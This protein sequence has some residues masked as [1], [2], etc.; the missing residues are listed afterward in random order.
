[1]KKQL[2]ILVVALSATASAAFSQ[3]LP[4][5]KPVPLTCILTDPLQPVAGRPYDYSAIINPTGGTAYWYATKSTTFTSAGVRVATEIPADGVAIATGA[6]NY[7]TSAV[8]PTSP[9]VT[10]VTWTS[11]GLAGIDATTNPL[12]MIVEYAG[13]TCSNNM[14]VMQI[15]PKNAF[16]VDITNMTHGVSPASLAYGA[17]ESQ[18]YDNVTSAVFNAG[19]IDIDY[20]TNVLYF[21]VIAANFS[22]SYLPTLK[23][24]GLQGTQTANIDWGYAIGTYSNNLVTNQTG[25]LITTA[26]FTVTTT[27]PTDQGISIY[28]RVTVKNHGWE[29]L[30]NDNITLAVEAVDAAGN[31]DV[32]PDCTTFIPFG[33]LAM[34]TLNARP[35]I[36]PGTPMIPQNP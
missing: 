21:E 27:V 18:C 33:D 14:K 5:T 29:G 23:L 25:S 19:K 16:T 31:K 22:N 28:V 17:A 13:P 9:T 2:L 34:Q 1:M 6:T 12:F 8:S 24:T 10:R 3:A 36:T 11:A 4:G 32:D 30:G 35:S 26:Q 15:I 7:R 20:G